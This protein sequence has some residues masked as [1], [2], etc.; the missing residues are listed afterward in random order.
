[1][2]AFVG[3]GHGK[4]IL[5]GEH[6]VVYGHP[7]LAVAVDRGVEVRL[8]RI[9]GPTRTCADTACD[10]RLTEALHAALEP[11]GWEVSVFSDLPIGR[12]MGS[13][14][15]ISVGLVRARAAADG[16]TLSL[17]TIWERAF[18]AEKAFHGNPS[19]LDQAVACRGGLLRYRKG[20]PPHFDDLPCPSWPLVV[21]DSGAAG[22]TRAL[23]EGVRER[24][25]G[26]QQVLE[27]I[28]SLVGKV[29]R[30]MNAPDQLGPLLTHNHTLLRHLGV[31]TPELDDLVQLA[32]NHGALGAKLAGAG[33]GGVV[34]ALTHDPKALEQAAR[35]RG[36]HAFTCH[37]QPGVSSAGVSP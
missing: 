19:G 18:A 7:A 9:D 34:L 16:E 11:T 29:E 23:V 14:A 28:G 21:L 1:M 20:P 35:A 22:D 31:S 25:P 27:A 33:G 13:S 15:A 17:Q 4:L 12:G 37:P 5:A 24:H 3:R 32:L 10:D 26:N 30:A 36:I 8:T 6:A 2:S